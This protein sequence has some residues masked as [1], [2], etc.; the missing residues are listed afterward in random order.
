MLC[1]RFLCNDMAGI[2]YEIGETVLVPA[3]QLD[4]NQDVIYRKGEKTWL[5]F[6][7]SL[8]IPMK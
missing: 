5:E 1:S 6:L 7:M 4:Y 3:N 8:N 2:S